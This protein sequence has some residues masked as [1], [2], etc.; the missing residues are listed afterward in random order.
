MVRDEQET[1][2]K[3]D[4]LYLCYSGGCP[5]LLELPAFDLIELFEFVDCPFDGDCIRTPLLRKRLRYFIRMVGMHFH[6]VLRHGLTSFNVL[7]SLLE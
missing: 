2:K 4:T 3:S 7:F 1:G 6:I 5:N